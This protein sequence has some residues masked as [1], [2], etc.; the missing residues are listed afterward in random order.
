LADTLTTYFTDLFSTSNPTQP[1]PNIH[2]SP[3]HHKIPTIPSLLSLPMI[4]PLI[5]ILT[6]NLPTFI[7]WDRE[8]L[9]NNK[10]RNC[11]SMLGSGIPTLLLL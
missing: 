9:D 1:I 4:M 3:L 5:I 10:L 6:L 11:I 2:T 8:I 7:C